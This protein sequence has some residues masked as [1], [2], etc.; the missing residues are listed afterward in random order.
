[1]IITDN[2]AY[3]ITA[4]NIGAVVNIGNSSGIYADNTADAVR[5][6]IAVTIFSVSNAG[7]IGVFDLTDIGFI[8]SVNISVNSG[9]TA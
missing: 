2:T 8:I 6:D 7:I 5:S 4:G 1:M 3:V 9:N